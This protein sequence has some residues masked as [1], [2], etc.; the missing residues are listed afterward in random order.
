M[1]AVTRR[2]T[3]GEFGVPSSA[4]GRMSPDDAAALRDAVR[5]LERTTLA[6]RL[7]AMA[8]KPI[9]LIGSLVPSVVTDTVSRATEAALKAALR[10]AIATVQRGR[11]PPRPRLNA[12]LAGASGAIGG[13]FGLSTLPLEL[14]ISTTLMLRAIAETAKREG[15]D[16]SD[17]DA[18]LACL[19]VFA[20]GGRTPADD[21]AQSGYFAVRGLLAKSMGEAARLFA[22]KGLLDETAP[23]MVR[24]VGQIA[25][26]FGVVVSQKAAATAIPIVGA[27]GGA[28]V[29]MAFMAH[30]QG[31][32]AAHFTVRRLERAYGQD[33]IRESYDAIREAG[34]A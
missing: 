6:G 3:V 15:E 21:A 32:A 1:S 4:G 18:A 2:E 9:E 28:A 22:Q 30:F 17:P 10:V 26:R 31:I 16:L 29:N 27:V 8:G 11:A 12:A 20:L 24:L 13:A 34:L 7:A 33:T 14:P 23:A 19:Q 5:I 25:A